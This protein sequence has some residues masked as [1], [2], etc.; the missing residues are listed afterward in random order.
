MGQ[1]RLAVLLCF[2]V[3]LSLACRGSGAGPTPSASPPVPTDEPTPTMSS[4]AA[5]PAATPTATAGL[6]GT[7]PPRTGP[8]TAAVERDG[9][10]VELWLPEDVARIG[11]RTFAH[12]R[13]TNRTERSV[14]YEGNPCDASLGARLD[15][16]ASAPAG[17]SWPGIAGAFKARLLEE[18]SYGIRYFM[19]VERIDQEQRGCADVGMTT[20]LGLGATL[21]RTVALDLVGYPGRPIFPGPATALGR[22]AY[23]PAETYEGQEVVVAEAPIGIEGERTPEYWIVDFVDRALAE[24][25]FAEWLEQR[26]A[27]TWIN[28]HSTAWPN[29]EGRYPADPCYERAT[30]GALD[31]GLFREVP[32]VFEFGSVSLDLPS[33]ELLGVRFESEGDRVYCD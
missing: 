7:A 22:F 10:L 28:T 23:W 16:T 26:P 25:R 1:R 33:G 4:P 12:V 31:I 30:D 11:E 20:G 6:G 21:E 15:Y 24:P 5:T 19:D 17:R 29:E 2:I 32:G 14:Q 9:I 8:P 3:F 13:V 18:G 27:E